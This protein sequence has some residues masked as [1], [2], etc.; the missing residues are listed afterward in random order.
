MRLLL[1]NTLILFSVAVAVAL[2]ETPADSLDESFD[3]TTLSDWKTMPRT[4]ERVKPR[5]EEMNTFNL[6]SPG[7]I[8]EPKVRIGYRVQIFITTDYLQA[9]KLDSLARTIWKEEVYMRFDSPYY[10]IRIG[11]E[12]RRDVAERLQQQAFRAGFRTAWVVRTEIEHKEKD[13]N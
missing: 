13:E 5:K 3:P 10:K 4:L 6:M 12:P 2:P 11:N 9:L 7:G 8:E 1:F